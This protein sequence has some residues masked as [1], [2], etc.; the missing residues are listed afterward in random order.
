MTLSHWIFG[1]GGGLLL[2][3]FVW[4]AFGQGFKTKPDNRPDSGSGGG[5][6]P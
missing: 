1:V 4:F 3:V 6:F 2:L 5:Q